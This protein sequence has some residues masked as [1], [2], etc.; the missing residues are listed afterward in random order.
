MKSLVA[1]KISN[2]I[3]LCDCA[4]TDS[5]ILKDSKKIV[6]ITSQYSVDKN[7]KALVIGVNETLPCVLIENVGNNVFGIKHK[8]YLANHPLSSCVVKCVNKIYCS[9]CDATCN[10]IL[11]P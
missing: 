1:M 10:R 7:V 5:V 3:L 9:S 4:I 8:P 11:M 6:I 2:P